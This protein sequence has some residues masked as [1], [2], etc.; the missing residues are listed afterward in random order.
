MRALGECVAF[1]GVEIETRN[2][3]LHEVD[4]CHARRLP[5]QS[6][7]HEQFPALKEKCM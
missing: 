2:D 1:V 3:V 5:V 7:E 4:R 6:I